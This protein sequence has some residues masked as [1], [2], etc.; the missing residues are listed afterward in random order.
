LDISQRLKRTYAEGDLTDYRFV[1][2][3]RRLQEMTDIQG[4]CERIRN[5]PIPFSY[6]ILLHRIV[7]V[8]VFAL[9]FGLVETIHWMSPVVVLIVAYTFL[10]LDAVGD[11]IEDPFGFHANDL[12]LSSLSRMIEINLRQALGETDIPPMMLPDRGV[13]M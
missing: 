9:P 3:E 7:A 12:P 13:L 1:E 11:E 5:T 4:G 6:S 2:I 10:A 8:Y